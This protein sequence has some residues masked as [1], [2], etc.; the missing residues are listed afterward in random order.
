M[1]LKCPT[2]KKPYHLKKKLLSE[3]K[4]LF[5]KA[6]EPEAIRLANSGTKL[7]SGTE[8][9]NN[10]WNQIFHRQMDRMAKAEGLRV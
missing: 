4:I 9:K 7:I 5:I 1:S 10:K 3:E 2:C 6:L 8:E